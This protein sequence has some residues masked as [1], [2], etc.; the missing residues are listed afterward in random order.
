MTKKPN[1]ICI[2][3]MHRS[4]TSMVAR[5]LNICG[6]ELGKPEDMI[7]SIDGNEKG[8]WENEKFKN[9]NDEIILRYIDI[10]NPIKPPIFPSYFERSSLLSDLK[11]RARILIKNYDKKYRV[12]GWKDP[13]NCLTLPFW[14]EILGKRLKYIVVSRQPIDVA[15]SLLKRDKT[16]IIENLTTWARYVTDSIIYTQNHDRFFIFSENIFSNH[17]KQIN[18][19][20][21]FV[22][23]TNI[24]YTNKEKIIVNQFISKDLWH[25]QKNK[26]QLKNEQDQL[27]MQ[28]SKLYHDAIFE[29]VQNTT[30]E[31]STIKDSKFYKLY[32]IYTKIKNIFK[33]YIKK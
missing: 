20:V 25:H 16:P 30:Q 8:H 13:R 1:V 14:Q 6:L 2:L 28:F 23:N 19:L 33:K 11:E 27:L 17:H 24:K 10:N 9:I 18:E 3:G 21:K 22:N 12:W 15:N 31:L 32:P 26:L 29:I 4:G 5:I 7:L